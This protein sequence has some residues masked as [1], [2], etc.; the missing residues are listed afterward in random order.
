MLRYADNDVKARIFLENDIYG[1]KIVYRRVKKTN[2]LVID[3]KVYGEYV[4]LL[5]RTH[6][7]TA[8]VDGHTYGAGFD[9]RGFVYL[10]VDGRMNFELYRNQTVRILKAQTDTKLIR[11][12]PCGFYRK[13]RQKMD[14]SKL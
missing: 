4:A 6:L 3:G 11:L 14:A 8:A 10:T 7:L 9:G 2:E 13:L 5:E 1:H 12:K